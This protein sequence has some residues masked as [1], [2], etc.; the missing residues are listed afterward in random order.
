MFCNL[1]MASL[2]IWC[3]TNTASIRFLVMPCVQLKWSYLSISMPLSVV[4]LI[5]LARKVG[6]S[7]GQNHSTT[8]PRYTLLRRIDYAAIHSCLLPPAPLLPPL[9]LG[10]ACASPWPCLTSLAVHMAVVTLLAKRDEV[11]L[12]RVACRARHVK[13]AWKK[14]ATSSGLGTTA[15]T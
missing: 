7:N 15:G 3:A 12:Q 1:S 5:R 4:P 10:P 9:R 8:P 6:G 11:A 2:L 14:A 13:A